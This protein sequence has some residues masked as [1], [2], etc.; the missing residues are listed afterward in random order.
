MSWQAWLLL[1]LAIAC[2]AGIFLI[3][4]RYRKRDRDDIAA[5]ERRRG[6]DDADWFI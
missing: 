6:N 5:N 2:I 1:V 3:D 4:S